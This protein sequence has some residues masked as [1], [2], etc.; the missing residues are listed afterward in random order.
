ML[1]KLKNI[2]DEIIKS[3]NYPNQQVKEMLANQILNF[4]ISL[5]CQNILHIDIKPQN[6]LISQKGIMKL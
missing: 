5:H 6:Y 4:L 2:I 1:D 3:K